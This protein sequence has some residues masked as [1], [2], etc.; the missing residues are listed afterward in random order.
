MSCKEGENMKSK[1]AD[2]SMETIVAAIIVLIVLVVSITLYNRYIK[3][4]TGTL[5][6]QISQLDSEHDYDDDGVIDLF[7]PCPCEPGRERDCQK[8]AKDCQEL[9]KKK[10]A[11]ES[12]KTE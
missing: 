8:S 12:A 5:D 2:I 11:E 10:K 6:D 9:I 1:K 7:D 3:R 4:S